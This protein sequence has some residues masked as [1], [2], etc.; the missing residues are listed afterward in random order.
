MPLF[1]F[2][3]RGGGDVCL[4]TRLLLCSREGG[5]GFKPTPSPPLT[6]FDDQPGLGWIRLM[7]VQSLF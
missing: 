3:G 4:F 2:W 5:G 6:I 7:T 1:L